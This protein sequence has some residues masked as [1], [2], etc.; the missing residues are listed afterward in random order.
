MI[1]REESWAGEVLPG[2]KPLSR[3]RALLGWLVVIAMLVLAAVVG[4]AARRYHVHD[5]APAD[6]PRAVEK[7]ISH[8]N[9][10]ETDGREPAGDGPAQ[11]S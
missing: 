3:G 1:E 10:L 4:A 5:P 11:V 2:L 9:V 7:S 6:K 8:A